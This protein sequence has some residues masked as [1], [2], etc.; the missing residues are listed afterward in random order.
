MGI[1]A[2]PVMASAHGAD[3]NAGMQMAE[4]ISS[5]TVKCD[6]VLDAQF[7]N[8]GDYFMEQM[9]GQTHE[10]MD[11]MMEQMMGGEEGL[12][13]MHAAM[14]KRMSGCET[15]ASMPAG[16]MSGMSGMMSMMG[17]MGGGAMGSGMLGGAS[18]M[19]GTQNLGSTCRNM[20][21]GV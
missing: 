7:E 21:S 2:F 12:T 16:M 1:L 17:M 4:E 6:A 8:M 13:Q 9:M 5:G 14:G 15:N 18:G 20:M 19:M 10:Q 3:R 11:T